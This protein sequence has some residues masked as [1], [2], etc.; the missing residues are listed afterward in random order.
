MRYYNRIDVTEETDI[1]NASASRYCIICHCLE[2]NGLAFKQLVSID[3]I[4][5]NNIV[6][7]STYDAYY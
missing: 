6:I 2:T 3:S 7:L 1:N 4:G 5:I